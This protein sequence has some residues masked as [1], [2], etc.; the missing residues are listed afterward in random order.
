MEELLMPFQRIFAFAE[1][2]I[3]MSIIIRQNGLK[4]KVNICVEGIFQPGFL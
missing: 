1:N 4:M 2:K 3:K